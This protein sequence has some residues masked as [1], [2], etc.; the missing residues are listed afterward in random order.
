MLPGLRVESVTVV[1]GRHEVRVHRVTGAPAGARVTHTGWATGPE[2]EVTSTLH[3]L[4]GW[5]P[6]AEETR[7][8]QG[9][10][11]TRWA[12]V[13]RLTGETSGT[14]LH[15]A[16]AVLTA[17]PEPLVPERVVSGV[18]ATGTTA[19]ITWAEDGTRTRITFDPL[20]VRHDEP[21]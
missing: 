19:E 7:A 17:D 12:V 15:V 21:R 2:E 14:S 6:D 8:P 18:E 13:P 11:Y 4:Y 20:T 10:A 9:T 5:N 1:R 3:G 16:L